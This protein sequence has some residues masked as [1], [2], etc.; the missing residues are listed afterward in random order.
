MKPFHTIAAPHDDI[1]R[2]RLTMDVFAADLWDTYQGRGP[3]EY[4]DP[5]TFFRKTHMTANMSE[6]LGGVQ[7]RLAGEGGDG[8]QHIETPFGG[9]KTHALIAMYHK[10]REWGAKCV[11]IVGTAMGPE[12]T[13]WGKIE[14]QLDGRVDALSGKLA[15]GRE[16]LRHVLERHEPVLILID[17]L[18]PYV[19]VAAGVQLNDTNLATQTITFIQQ[20]SEATSTLDRV[21]VVASFPASI[22]EMADKKTAEELLAKIRKVSGRKERKIAPV[23]PNDIPSIIRSRLFVT[24]GNE[25]QKNSGETVSAFVEYCESEFILPPNT[26]VMQYK[27]EFKN[28]Y[29]FLPEVIDV[30]YHNWGS[31]SSFQ[32]TRGLLRL[33]SHVVYSLRNSDRPYITLSD[34][35]LKD[36]DIRRELLGHIGDEFDSI[37]SKDITDENSGARRAD[38]DTGASNKG[39]RLGTKSAVAIF[40]HSFSSGGTNGAT[41]SEIKRATCSPG[42][43]SSIVGEIV[44]N[45]KNKMS[46]IK[47]EDGKYVI[48]SEPNINRLKIDKMD[49]IKDMEI[50][51]NEHEILSESLGSRKITT[52]LWPAT[53]SDIDD[54]PR[55]KLAIMKDNDTKMLN[56]MLENKGQVP[57]IYRNSVFFLTP[58]DAERS[59]FIESLKGKIALEKILAEQTSIKSK[60]KEDI[61]KN[62][63]SEKAS[64]VHLIRKYYRNLYIPGR[65]GLEKYDMG[66]PVVGDSRGIT[67]Q[68]FERLKSEQQVHESIG[69]L[70][71]QD[72]CLAGQDFAKTVSMYESMLKVRGSRRPVDRE[73]V[74]EAIRQGVLNK[75]FGLGTLT[76]GSVVCQYFGSSPPVEFSETEVIIRSSECEKMMQKQPNLD[77]SIDKKSRENVDLGQTTEIKNTD[78]RKSIELEFD[79]PDGRMNDLWELLQGINTKFQSIHFKIKAG[80][81]HVTSDYME[82]ISETLNQI[83]A[84]YSLK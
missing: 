1:A 8:F 78:K 58:S 27:N 75:K 45:L 72:D 59:Q 46:Y 62:L 32:R 2:K 82:E 28:T 49:S 47:D 38:N 17:E 23:N 29:P 34:F 30:L 13:V 14:E 50:L 25:I 9:G 73:V 3:E 68:V 51:E 22:L 36:D 33:L 48:T 40:M 67:S 84:K 20:L 31:F 60:Q 42:T 18:L 65:V 5:D 81:G 57:R 4:T 7:R 6:I 12:D 63:K 26:T 64:L 41:V 66:I 11:V 77:N 83:G 19:S 76:N 53:P 44:A 15:P 21:C 56:V 35:D 10:A 55:M 70:V 39:L 54:L 71:I 74:K 61:V 52:V 79:L 69:P 80:D 24:D 37:M 16:N 43:P